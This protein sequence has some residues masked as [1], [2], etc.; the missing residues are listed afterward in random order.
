M[1]TVAE[2]Q[3]ILA[4][5]RAA[6][7]E[8]EATLRTQQQPPLTQR[9]LRTGAAATR[10]GKLKLAAVFQK[11]KEV[12]LG[13]IAQERTQ[14][15]TYAGDIEAAKEFDKETIAAQVQG[16]IRDVTQSYN[17]AVQSDND[18]RANRLSSE[19]GHLA[20][21]T[22]LIEEGYTF[23]QI[24]GWVNNWVEYDMAKSEQ[25]QQLI[26][27]VRAKQAALQ[28]EAEAGGYEIERVPS[29][30]VTPLTGV[31]L[32]ADVRRALLPYEMVKS[33][34]SLPTGGIVTQSQFPSDTYYGMTVV[35]S[36]KTFGERFAEPFKLLSEAPGIKQVGALA[37]EG[38]IKA[39]PYVM[40]AARDVGD[41]TVY[42]I[43]SSVFTTPSSVFKYPYE[44]G[45]WLGGKGVTLPPKVEETARTIQMGAKETS[46]WT[47]AS[48]IPVVSPF[49][50]KDYG[51]EGY[52]IGPP[53]LTT[54]GGMAEGIWKT[55]KLFAEEA[56]LPGGQKGLLTT[57]T[58]GWGQIG[59][60][61]AGRVVPYEEK[62]GPGS[63]VIGGTKE[64]QEKWMTQPGF[65]EAEISRQ[66]RIEKG[67]SFI[68]KALPAATTIAA[69]TVV[70]GLAPAY[71]AG[72]I[73]RGGKQ[74]EDIDKASKEIIDKEYE[75]YKKEY[76]KTEIPEG[77]ELEP[78]LS[79][80][81]YSLKRKIG[82]QDLLSTQIKTRIGMDVA[83]LATIGATKAVG[84]VIKLARTPTTKYR[85]MVPPK[86]GDLHWGRKYS[87]DVKKMGYYEYPT[88]ELH[89]MFSAK[90]LSQMNLAGKGK[91]T[92]VQY[93]PTIEFAK[94]TK[95]R[96]FFH[97]APKA[98]WKTYQ[99]S[100]IR[101][102]RPEPKWVPITTKR[103]WAES[104]K[105][106]AP[107]R[108]LGSKEVYSTA[109]RRKIPAGIKVQRVLVQGEPGAKLKV[110]GGKVQLPKDAPKWEKEIWKHMTVLEKGQV[111]SRS[112]VRIIESK[113]FKAPSRKV[114]GIKA[115]QKDYYVASKAFPKL[116]GVKGTAQKIETIA[117]E[118]SISPKATG[119]FPTHETIVKTI[120]PKPQAVK[121]LKPAAIEKTPFSKT[122]GSIP[123]TEVA[124]KEAAKVA[125]KVQ[126]QK[127][128]QTMRE[129]IKPQFAA[130]KPISVPK[131]RLVVKDNLPYMVGGTGLAIYS[132]TAQA[133]DTR[134]QLSFIEITKQEEIIKSGGGYGGG[135]I[136]RVVEIPIEIQVPKEI[137]TPKEIQIPKQAQIPRQIPRQI[138]RQISQE[139]KK[140]PTPTTTGTPFVKIPPIPKGGRR[141]KPIGRIQ[142][143]SFT[144]FVKRYQKW[145][146]V[147]K[148]KKKKEEA[149][150]I[151]LGVL[152]RTLAASLQIRGPKGV[153]IPFAPPTKSEFRLGKGTS[154]ILVQR[155]PR[156]LKA[157]TEVREI[158]STRR[159]P[160][161]GS[162]LKNRGK[163]IKFF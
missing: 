41:T 159:K 160:L 54:L 42:D 22:P 128:A 50:F 141:R 43:S 144:P 85:Q 98:P 51:A 103:Y 105:I 29:T 142:P 72:D 44:F 132:P 123:K 3:Q 97:L 9:Q 40:K 26:I 151:G 149:L 4:E 92:M 136:P 73:L 100:L 48:R 25:K 83:F 11:A 126:V 71:F 125:T 39:A 157:P 143:I 1:V 84:K 130:V 112:Y 156:R 79:L 119:K 107:S 35:P 139:I 106:K 108:L 140:T 117:K 6:A 70:P 30:T 59:G 38:I 104:Y 46:I 76:R 91:Y 75:Q 152:R 137:V 28:A 14:L 86:P 131:I 102:I 90:E 24:K 36:P 146:P 18:E 161:K 145:I 52:G 122:F 15:A 94:T 158:I 56:P 111:P 55:T 113:V 57:A 88:R 80:Q 5:R 133:Y 23:Q 99:Q 65:R 13:Q 109:L 7:G 34:E 116:K 61:V 64:Y 8:A 27:D 31:Q 53:K 129:I 60:Y 67:I 96:E 16:R 95:F 81:E 49:T 45:K 138:Y 148:P 101:V 2:A 37:T 32:P 163:N 162:P 121:V 150:R 134:Q 74:L 87:Y 58:K 10:T 66:Q 120:Y 153:P 20:Q 21:T 124:I 89:K 115:T 118:L 114:V 93:K 63:G 78:M 147:S 155:A 135:Q 127:A 33:P 82:I 17:S 69:F 62:L 12:A 154:T 19:L 47:A 77:Y 68:G 110:V